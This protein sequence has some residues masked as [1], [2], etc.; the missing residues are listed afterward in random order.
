M[1]IRC[2]V[3]SDSRACRFVGLLLC[4]MHC[5]LVSSSWLFPPFF[6]FQM[7]YLV[8]RRPCMIHDTGT[9]GTKQHYLDGQLASVYDQLD[10]SRIM[11]AVCI[12]TCACSSRSEYTYTVRIYAYLYS[13]VSVNQAHCV[14]ESVESFLSRTNWVT[15]VK[16]HTF[17]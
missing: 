14:E 6:F 11:I 9:E 17:I 3:Y 7:L 10:S 16:P 13:L 15:I 12:Y 1:Y 2:F 8:L 5:Y 4:L